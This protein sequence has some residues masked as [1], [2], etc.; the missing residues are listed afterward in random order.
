MGP[1]ANKMAAVSLYLGGM[2]MGPI[3][4]FEL[5]DYT[6]LP[7]CVDDIEMS[8]Q[9]SSGDPFEDILDFAS[10]TFSVLVPVQTIP[11]RKHKKRRIQKKWNKRYGVKTICKK[12][13]GVNAMYYDDDGSVTMVWKR[14]GIMSDVCEVVN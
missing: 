8:F 3:L 14:G 5:D 13:D 6:P 12:L 2:E 9:Y 11:V 4:D 1:D 7:P 10:N